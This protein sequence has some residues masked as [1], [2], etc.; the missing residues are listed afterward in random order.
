MELFLARPKAAIES[1]LG[2][3]D[4]LRGR[5][6]TATPSHELPK[7]RLDTLREITDRVPTCLA[8]LSQSLFLIEETSLDVVDMETRMQNESRKLGDVL[9]RLGDAIHQ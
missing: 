2:A 8:A 5:I 4:E 6:N 7:S 3:N 9:G 1:T